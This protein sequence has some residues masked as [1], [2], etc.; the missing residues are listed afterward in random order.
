MLSIKHTDQTKKKRRNVP[1]TLKQFIMILDYNE[2]KS[3]SDLSD[4][5][6]T[7][8]HCLQRGTKWYSKLAFELL[9]GSEMVN[10]NIVF[11]VPKNKITIT[12][13]KH[14]TSLKLR[15]TELVPNTK[16]DEVRNPRLL[17]AKTKNRC[18]VCYSSVKMT[19]GRKE[20]QNKTPRS[21]Y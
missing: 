17:D 15:G 16:R 5:R 14:S 3:F 11:K 13:F 18:I 9:F 7:Y 20:A 19:L 4:K 8:L 2:C 1:R 6:K 12:N 21:K 10:A